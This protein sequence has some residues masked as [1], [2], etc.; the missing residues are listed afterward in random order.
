SLGTWSTEGLN[1]LY[2]LQLLVVLDDGQV[3][4]A[5]TP[6]TLDNVAPSVELLVPSVG[7]SFSLGTADKLAISVSAVDEVGLERID[8]FVD[9]RRM[10]TATAAPYTIDWTFPER[11]GDHEIYARAYDTAGNRTET[12]RVLIQIVP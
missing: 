5:A 12:Q 2:T 10:G 6:V 1:G 11:M 3:R 7:D 8:F 9:G 4:T